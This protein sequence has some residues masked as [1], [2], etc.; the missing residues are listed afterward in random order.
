[1]YDRLK[2]EEPYIAVNLLENAVVSLD[3][4]VRSV[5]QDLSHIEHYMRGT[6]RH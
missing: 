6:G 3:H 1:M 5:S 2:V 4:L